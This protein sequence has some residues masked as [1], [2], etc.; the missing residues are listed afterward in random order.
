[1]IAN[2]TSLERATR[3]L[4][5]GEVLPSSHTQ[6]NEPLV[7][8]LSETD[9]QYAAEAR[10][11]RNVQREI[12][13]LQGRKFRNWLEEQDPNREP[14][15]LERMGQKAK[16]KII[17]IAPNATEKV[18]ELGQNMRERAG[19]LYQKAS[20]VYESVQETRGFMALENSGIGMRARRFV[21]EHG[22]SAALK[23]KISQQKSI[24][25]ELVQKKQQEENGFDRLTEK[26]GERRDIQKAKAE[27]SSYWDAQIA[28]EKVELT[29][30]EEKEKVKNYELQT[31]KESQN[32]EID[33]KIKA[34]EVQTDFAKNVE[35]QG[36][37]TADI[38][39]VQ[40]YLKSAR[41][42]FAHC[43]AINKQLLDGSNFQRSYDQIFNQK[44]DADAEKKISAEAKNRRKDA[45]A[46]IQDKVDGKKMSLETVLQENIFALR[47]LR[48]MIETLEKTEKKLQKAKNKIDKKVVHSK[49]R[50]DSWEV[51]RTKLGLVKEDPNE[52]AKANRMSATEAN[53]KIISIDAQFKILDE[54]KINTEYW[55]GADIID[56]CKQ[57]GLEN[58]P[59]GERITKGFADMRKVAEQSTLDM[60]QVLRKYFDFRL[61]DLEA[62]V[63][64]AKKE[65]TQAEK[66]TAADRA[67]AD[68]NHK[69]R[70]AAEEHLEEVKNSVEKVEAQLQ[71]SREKAEEFRANI[72]RIKTEILE[73]IPADIANKAQKLSDLRKLATE[74]FPD[75]AAAET[76]YMSGHPEDIPEAVP[77]PAPV[78]SP[79]ALDEETEKDEGEPDIDENVP[80]V[81][82]GRSLG[83]P[84]AGLA[85]LPKK[86]PGFFRRIF[87]GLFGGLFGR[88]KN[89]KSN[90]QNK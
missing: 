11:T 4:A 52:R 29:R 69:D 82:F 64:A 2:K 33:N 56:S 35:I 9:Q 8:P 38:K 73:K 40:N 49:H 25:S 1:M 60:E 19:N 30:L 81:G 27:K 72:E 20:N 70:K 83:M 78:T 22:P 87:G 84:T 10:T 37:M 41:N 12:R 86:K 90:G 43:L 51:Q 76:E 57:H 13:K 5:P 66:E 58:I 32:N 34:I 63:E 47:K 6:E 65:Y 55:F 42:Q 50:Q 45:L 28:K 67:L 44:P 77:T 79:E 7:A 15:F 16:G 59:A 75:L 14:G 80:P 31:I 89:D 21:L 23:S 18:V 68:P 39:E 74:W 46:T 61:P 24:I 85:P 54:N 71:K 53:P 17:E 36:K 48:P 88:R 62:E 3:N 26:M